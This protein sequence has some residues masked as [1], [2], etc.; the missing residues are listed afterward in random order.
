MSSHQRRRPETSSENENDTTQTYSRYHIEP[1]QQVSS[2][3][4]E[5]LSTPQLGM[6][7]RLLQRLAG[8]IWALARQC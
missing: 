5:A 6:P 8:R 2:L 4:D 3:S 7:P 1:L